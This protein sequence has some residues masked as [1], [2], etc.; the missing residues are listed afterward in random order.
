MPA[1]LG[2]PF[3][4]TPELERR[5]VRQRPKG[6]IR[7]FCGGSDAIMRWATVAAVSMLAMAA[8]SRS[9]RRRQRLKPRRRPSRAAAK[10]EPLKVGFVYVSPIGDAA[11]HAAQPRREQCRPRSARSHHQLR[12]KCPRGRPERVIRTWQRRDTS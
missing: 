10:A 6:K 1:S 7:R 8:A 3:N 11:D 5:P 9:L 4:R 12:E 2:K